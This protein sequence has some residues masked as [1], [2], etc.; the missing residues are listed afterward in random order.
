MKQNI[1]ERT[2]AHTDKS[3]HGEARVM[4]ITSDKVELGHKHIK[5]VKK[6]SV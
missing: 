6:S 4:A 3:R 2:K 1:Q 5:C